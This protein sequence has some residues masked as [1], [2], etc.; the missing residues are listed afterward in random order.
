[1]KNKRI[2]FSLLMLLITTSIFSQTDYSKGFKAGF[3]KGYCYEQP[4][5]IAP[6]PPVT[7]TLRIG[8]A[9]VSY[10]DGYNRGFEMG[11]SR[12]LNGESTRSNNSSKVGTVT[13]SKFEPMYDYSSFNTAVKSK[14]QLIY[15]TALDYKSTI[16]E[17][18]KSTTDNQLKR[19]LYKAKLS[20]DRVFVNGVRLGDA[21]NY[22][23][24]TRRLYNKAFRQYKKRIKKN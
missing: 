8:E 7:P 13:T 18:M 24:A 23:K 4:S 16:E 14:A 1:M 20:L 6:T 21:E 5:C 12:R 19:D 2:K 15:N 3:K 10:T 22:L 11:R 17:A 9:Y